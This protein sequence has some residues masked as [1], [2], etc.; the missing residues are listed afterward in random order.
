MKSKEEHEKAILEIIETFE[1]K[2]VQHIFQHYTDLKSAQF[3]NLELE[4]SECIKDAIALNKSKACTY[5]INKWIQSDNS[6]LQISAFKVLCDE[7][8]RKK[9]SMNYTENDVKFNK[10]SPLII[11]ND[12]V[13]DWKSPIDLGNEKS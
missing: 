2:K 8:D 1:I 5:M 3:Y 7:E 9:L 4:K 13:I 10:D 6:T 12:F 11:E